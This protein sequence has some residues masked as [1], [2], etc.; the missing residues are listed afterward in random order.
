MSDHRMIRMPQPPYST[1][2]A[3]SDFGLFRR[4]KNRLEQIQAC[5]LDEI[6]SSI[7]A[8]ELQRVFAACIDRVRQ[9]SEGDGEY[10]TS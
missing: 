6:P 5:E 4:V 3:L 1:D 9:V 2:L 8:E 7:S 10:L